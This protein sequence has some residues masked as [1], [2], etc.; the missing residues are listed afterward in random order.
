MTD[1]HPLKYL[2]TQKTL[3][4]K[5]ARWVEFMQEFNYSIKLYQKKNQTQLQTHYHGKNKNS[6]SQINRNCSKLLSIT[7]VKI[8]DEAINKLEAEY[9]NDENFKEK[10]G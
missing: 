6:S 2:D 3:S 10:M 5:Q 4:R 1:H 7:Q 8:S 9:K